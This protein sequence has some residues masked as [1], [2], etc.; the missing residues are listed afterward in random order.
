M[1]RGASER[2]RDD[3]QTEAARMIQRWW[4]QVHLKQTA[5]ES[6]RYI[7]HIVSLQQAQ[8]KSF[9][10]LEECVLDENTQTITHTLLMHLEQMKDIIIPARHHVFDVRCPERV[11]LSAYLIATKSDHIFESPT[12]IDER[13]LTQ[14]EAML[15]S[16]ENLCRFMSETYMRDIPT[17]V[18]SPLACETP[19]SDRVFASMEHY[20]LSQSQER[21][22]ADKR[23]MK[24]G[25]PYLEAF[26][27]A[28]NAYYETF[29]EWES[30]NRARLAKVCIDQYLRIEIKRFATL[31]NPDPRQLELYDG[32]GK[33]LDSLRKKINNLLGMDGIEQLEDN[34]QSLKEA[35]EANKWMSSPN[36]VLVHEMALNP[37]FALPAE[38]FEVHPQHDIDL[39]ISALASH[40]HEPI[41]AVIEEIRDR[42]AFLTPHNG[43]R[44]RRLK[45][46][47]SKESVTA[48]IESLGLEVGLYKV[49]NAII[50]ELK[51]AGSEAHAPATTEFQRDLELRLD[52]GANS[53]VLLKESVDF[54]YNKFSEINREMADFVQTLVASNPIDYEKQAFY[55]RLQSGQFNLA[56]VLGWID[57]MVA[58]PTTYRLNNAIL[59][60]QYISSHVANAICLGVIQQSGNFDLAALPETF[61]LDRVRFMNWHEQYQRIFHTAAAMGYLDVFCQKYGVKLS[62]EQLLMQKNALIMTL[63]EEQLTEPQAIAAHVLETLHALLTKHGKR[64]SAEEER[65]QTKIIEDI[66]T[67]SHR[68]AEIFHKRLGDQLS[69][70]FFK[71]R[72]PEVTASQGKLYGLREE[73]AELGKEIVPLLRHHVKVH[74]AFYYRHI[75]T[76]LWSPLFA[77]LR[78]PTLL[79]EAPSLLSSQQEWVEKVHDKLHKM[80]FL[81]SGLALVQQ[82][83]AFADM[84]NLNI[85]IKNSTLKSLAESS[86]L[87]EMISDSSVTKDHMASK[88]IELMRHVANE[89]ELSFEEEDERTFKKMLQ[90]SKSG[91]SPACKVF[92]DELSCTYRQF[93]IKEEHPTL[94][95]NLLTSEFSKE[96]I[97]MCQEVKK[98]V[99]AVKHAHLPEDVDPIAQTIPILRSGRTIGTLSL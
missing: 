62:S 90:F 20:Q 53:G 1:S 88:F 51:E 92:L 36:E 40:D 27:Q 91:Q 5:E 94:N 23:F 29:V 32:Y 4:K 11:F 96:I 79:P 76:R 7:K 67:G 41:L 39:A 42:L 61:Y 49:I 43:P 63:K 10:K 37:T 78:E 19:S 93:V 77:T 9:S 58:S 15:I 46:A 8:D 35:L 50:E 95:Q 66:C 30:N 6:S 31:N 21:M 81:L 48:E 2:R 75:Q 65:I 97:G 70:Y 83:V 60:S 34:L 13:L 71:G 85:G 82:T 54:I 69:F 18:G 25:R 59:C 16:F 12:N 44:I 56:N 72:L 22:R 80:A 45:E 98:L 74:D 14:A 17:H 52:L 55:N 38:C 87:V 99:D 73:L 86:G 64:L 24:E 28:Q 57:K 89:H 84:W 68:I 47:F 3:G 26:H 33:Q